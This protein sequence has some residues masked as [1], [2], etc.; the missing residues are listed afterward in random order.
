MKEERFGAV[1]IYCGDGK[2]KTT[3]GM[4]LCLRA[5]GAGRRV[6]IYQ[7]MKD[8]TS[9]ERQI[10]KKIP[11]ITLLD[12]F[13]EEKF[14]FQMTEEEKAQRR[15]YYGEKLQEVFTMAG[16]S[17]DLLFLDEVIYTVREGLLPEK[18]LLD[19]LDKRPE[20]LEVVMTGQDPDEKLLR[21]ADYITK[22]QKIRHPYDR[23]LCATGLRRFLKRSA[24]EEFQPF[25]FPSLRSY[26]EKKII[27]LECVFRVEL[28]TFYLNY[29]YK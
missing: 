18:L 22:M 21:R 12:G 28:K 14:S 13:P 15:V 1:H 3:C 20:G 24:P 17:Y 4:G 7:F 5:A 16:D 27:R 10:L 8:N 2:G 23:G 11:G 26:Y 25:G 19:C 29:L 9:G 6:L